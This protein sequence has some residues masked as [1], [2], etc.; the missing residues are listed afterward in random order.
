MVTSRRDF[1]RKTSIALAGGLI[2][3]DA[4]MEMFERLTHN[5]VFALGGV[6]HPVFITESEI[7]DMMKKIYTDM[8]REIIWHVS[9][10]S[11]RHKRN[12]VG[13]RSLHDGLRPAA[14]RAIYWDA[15]R[16]SGRQPS[17]STPSS[18]VTPLSS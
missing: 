1:L 10:Q 11:P 2:V 14:I 5:K 17:H 12:I 4:A 7:R 16:S 8:N 13:S 3:G 15:V 6:Q 18:G 9:P